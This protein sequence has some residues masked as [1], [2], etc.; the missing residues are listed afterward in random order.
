MTTID[1]STLHDMLR[2]SL[3]KGQNPRLT[4]ISN[5][6]APLIWEDDQVILE[7]IQPEQLHPGDII[8][9]H[10]NAGLLTHRIWSVH[11]KHFLT[12][13]DH[14][15]VFDK[16]NPPETIL[17]RVIGRTHKQRTLSFQ[18]GL[19]QWLDKHLAALIQQENR[20]LT[21]SQE[22]PAGVEPV[23]INSRTKLVHRLFFSWAIFITFA[24]NLATRIKSGENKI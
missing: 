23:V 19:G 15:L 1:S 22:A 8:T 12:R 24:V 6:M 4:V 10:D 14:V 3:A 11:D 7:A 20:W 9:I 5:S 2:D 21:G 17:G 18:T 16:L 13:G